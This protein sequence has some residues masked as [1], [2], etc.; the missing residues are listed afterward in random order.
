M[1]GRFGTPPGAIY[2]YRSRDAR[3]SI[4]LGSRD[5]VEVAPSVTVATWFNLNSDRTLLGGGGC[6]RQHGVRQVPPALRKW[7][8]ENVLGAKAG[9]ALTSPLTYSA[10]RQL[11]LGCRQCDQC[12]LAADAVAT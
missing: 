1:H 12:E 10:A 6:F 11:G 9:E 5:R 7:L 2:I 8:R 4:P 3:I